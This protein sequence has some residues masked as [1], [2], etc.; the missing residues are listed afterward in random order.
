M[1]EEM[2]K[3]RTAK[4][5]STQQSP[6][7]NISNK[8]K[9]VS[10]KSPIINLEKTSLTPFISK[11]SSNLSSTPKHDLS[12]NLD[13]SDDENLEHHQSKAKKSKGS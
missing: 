11:R 7:L 5:K 9:S 10:D 6:L 13:T 4:L 1:R 12:S 3:I 8:R 2:E